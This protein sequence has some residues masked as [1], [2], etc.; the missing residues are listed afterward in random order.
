[1]VLERFSLENKTAI[2]TGAAGGLGRAMALSLAKAGASI[3]IADIQADAAKESAKMVSQIGRSALALCT[4]VTSSEQVNAMVQESISALGHIDILIN[5]AGVVRGQ[6]VVDLWELTDDEWHLGQ[7]TNLGSV[8]YCTRAVAEH[9]ADREEGVI[10]NIASAWS[11]R[12][13]KNQ[14]IYNSAKAGVI[15]LT[16]DLAYSLAK[17]GIR[18]NCIAPGIMLTELV[19]SAV[20]QRYFKNTASKIPM[21]R[22]GKPEEIG[23]LAVFLAS[24]AFTYI[25]GQVIFLCGGAMAAGYAPPG[26][27]IPLKGLAE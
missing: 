25:T 9:M 26:Y 12:A 20:E 2:I 5:N 8:F 15:A 3:V 14:Y 21:G 19:K 11:L 6:R 27:P 10:I 1:M 4:D 17:S 16:R 13:G 18:V 7:E 23:E 22:L 24:D